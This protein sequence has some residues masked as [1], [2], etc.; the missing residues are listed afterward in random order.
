MTERT[1]TIEFIYDDLQ[2]TFQWTSDMTY[3]FKSLDLDEKFEASKLNELV[4]LPKK[5]K[6]TIVNM[7]NNSKHGQ[8]IKLDLKKFLEEFSIITSYDENMFKKSI[9]NVSTLKKLNTILEKEKSTEGTDQKMIIQFTNNM[10]PAGFF[11]G[12]DQDDKHQSNH[13]KFVSTITFTALALKLKHN[14][15][16]INV[17]GKEAMKIARKYKIESFPTFHYYINGE[18]QE[19]ATFFNQKQLG[20]ILENNTWNDTNIFFAKKKQQ[21]LEAYKKNQAME[22]I[23]KE[24]EMKKKKKLIP[25]MTAVFNAIGQQNRQDGTDGYNKSNDDSYQYDS[26]Y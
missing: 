12:F 7:L 25:N 6:Q 5:H 26:N 16:F 1:F 24:K 10:K 2:E 4:T 21:G 15:T 8:K 18:K 3:I 14:C 23:L 22:K 9:K 13:K 20:I 17:Q 19:E 11:P